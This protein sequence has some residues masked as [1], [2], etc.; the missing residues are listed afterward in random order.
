M[1]TVV[2]CVVIALTSTFSPV[3]GGPDSPAVAVMSVLA[4]SIADR[5]LRQGCEHAHDRHQCAG[6]AFGQHAAYRRPAL[7][8]RRAQV[9]P[10]AALHSLSGDRRL[11]GRLGHFAHHRRRGGGDPDQSHRCRRR[12]GQTCI[13]RSTGRKFSSACCSPSPSRCSAGWIPDY[14]GIAGRVLRLSDPARRELVRLGRRNGA[15]RLVSAEPRRADAVVAGQRHDRAAGRLGR[16][17][18]EQRRDR[19]VLR[20]DGHR[21]AARRVEPRSGAAEDRR[22][23]PGV[24]LQRARQSAGLGARRLW[25]LAVDECLPLARRVGR[26]DALGR[27]HRRYWSAPSSCSPAPMSAASCRRP[28]SAGCSPISAR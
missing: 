26:H 22:P 12:V 4:A 8:H 3:I 23:R 21:A 27:R 5:A 2:T 20:R 28:F 14:L 11:P 25:R 10:M 18:R 24:P 16:D 7:R 17:R 1:G 19:L 9:G 15:E 6:R 13:R